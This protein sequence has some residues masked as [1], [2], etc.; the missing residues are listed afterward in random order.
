MIS[1][2]TQELIASLR[3]KARDNTASLEELRQAFNLLREDRAR[4]G[5]VS[6]KAK[7]EKAT[8]AAAK[9]VDSDGLLDEL[10]GLL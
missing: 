6:S 9:N 2:Q 10:G 5:A 7:T 3:A 1:M 8:A 4:A